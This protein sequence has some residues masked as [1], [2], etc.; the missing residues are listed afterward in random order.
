MK[1]DRVRT[2]G[3]PLGVRVLQ[4]EDSDVKKALETPANLAIVT[5]IINKYLRQKD[6]LV[7]FRDDLLSVLTQDIG[8]KMLT[9][10]TKVDGKDV[11][12]PDEKPGEYLDRL[13]ASLIS[14][15]FSHAKLPVSGADNKSKE[16]SIYNAFQALA[17]LL[18]DV[19]AK[20][21]EVKRDEKTGRLLTP[22]FA[23]KLD[24]ARPERKS[25]KPKTPP[26]YAIEGAT[27][28]INNGSEAKWAEKFTKGFTDAQGVKI[29]PIAFQPF[30]VKPAKG[31]DAATVEATRQSNILAL[32]WA[33]A[34]KESQVREKTKAKKLAEFA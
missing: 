19:D 11:T 9:T 10:T 14:G 29:D 18:G 8:F 32:A 13:V 2:I 12:V 31:A 25:A 20:N 24:I 34:E 22:G 21:V 17:D 7:D 33:I 16:T 6:A 4:Y 30:D 23:Y 3:L 1:V 27:S 28:I 15:E 5:D 26:D